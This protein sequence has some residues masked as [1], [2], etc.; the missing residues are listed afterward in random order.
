MN[1]PETQ[2]TQGEQTGPQFVGGALVRVLNKS[3]SEDVLVS[4]P[5]VSFWSGVCDRFD[6]LKRVPAS[7]FDILDFPEC[8]PWI[9]RV[10][11]CVG[12]G[13]ANIDGIIRLLGRDLVAILEKDYTKT[14]VS[15]IDNDVL[16][17]RLSHILNATFKGSGPISLIARSSIPTRDFFLVETL[18]LPLVGADDVVSEFVSV[19][20][21]SPW[22]EYEHIVE[23]I[24]RFFEGGRL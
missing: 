9:T 18:A 3:T 10:E 13:S 5:M 4:K 22:A 20:V 1:G 6:D 2:E 8:V 11:H 24:L 23:P 7:E 19:T 15:E 17:A 12:E 21:V 16:R 14:L